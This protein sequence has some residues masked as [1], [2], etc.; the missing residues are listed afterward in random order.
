MAPNSSLISSYGAAAW[1]IATA[2]FFSQ[3]PQ[4]EVSQLITTAMR[5]HQIHYCVGADG[6]PNGFF[7]WA[8]LDHDVQKRVLAEGA[9]PP[10]LHPS[11]WREGTDAF[12][13]CMIVRGEQSLRKML[14]ACDANELRFAQA[15]TWIDWTQSRRRIYRRTNFHRE[16]ERHVEPSAITVLRSEYRDR[17]LEPTNQ[18]P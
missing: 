13:I 15:Y 14:N 8:W 18:K 11:E 4:F 16:V 6:V 7:I 12:L 2:P 9:W 10:K 17:A 3:T 5:L 1:L